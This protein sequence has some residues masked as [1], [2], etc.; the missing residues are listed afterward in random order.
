MKA[1]GSKLSL[2]ILAYVFVSIVSSNEM[3]K[4]EEKKSKSVTTFVSAK[5]E[6]TP[7]VLELAEYLAGESSDLFWSFVD[8]INSLKSSLDSLGKCM[9]HSVYLF[10]STHVRT[11]CSIYLCYQ[12]DDKAN[13]C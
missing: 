8:G 6:S 1:T 2:V 11:I 5:W 9:K 7:I 13:T 10:Y 12:R 3:A 4:R